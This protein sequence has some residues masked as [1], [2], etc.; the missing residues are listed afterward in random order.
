MQVVVTPYSTLRHA[1]ELVIKVYVCEPL[2]IL[3]LDILLYNLVGVQP[4]GFH[5]VVCLVV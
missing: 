3:C 4:C 2:Y 5:T 1:G